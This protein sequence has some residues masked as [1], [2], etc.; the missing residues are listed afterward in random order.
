[1]RR[2][3]Y[4]VLGVPS[5][6]APREIRQAYQRLARQYSPDVNFWDRDVQALYGEIQEAYRV[7]SDA[8]AREMYDRLGHQPAPDPG[9][10]PAGRRGEDLH[11]AVDLSF[12]DAARGATAPLQISRFSPCRV[13]EARGVTGPVTCPHCQGRGVRRVLES[14]VVEIPPG[15]D[16]GTQL[17]IAGEGHAGPFGGPR[18]DLIVSTRV[19]AH[20]FFSRKGDAVHCEVAITV[21][22]ALCGARIRIPTPTGEAVLVVP[23]GMHD[24][25]IVRL[26]GDGM[27]KLTG[28]G[29]GDLYVTVRVEVPGGI[30]ARTAEL[31]RELARLMPMDV[32]TELDRYRGGSA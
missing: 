27:P 29:S 4:G 21:W 23:P 15:V 18:G 12:G 25:R 11:A 8:V 5:T 13:C 24:G 16:S 2:D 7:L 1:M 30:D 19:A 3:Y 32:R 9:A 14:V 26:R 28:D 31:V 20:P 10:L 22:E 17:R 6:A